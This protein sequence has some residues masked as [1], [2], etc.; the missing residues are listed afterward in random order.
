M[1]WHIMALETFLV[2][3]LVMGVLVV[4]LALVASRWRSWRTGPMDAGAH[5]EPWLFRAGARVG[6][7]ARTPAAWG[8]AFAALLL[9]FG[10]GTL[11]LLTGQFGTAALLGMAVAGGLVVGGYLFYGTYASARMHGLGNAASVAAGSW[12]VGLLFLLVLTVKLLVA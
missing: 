2:S 12:A 1:V 4:A 10:G 7:F 3:S 9:V 5:D 8:V 11:L 6:S